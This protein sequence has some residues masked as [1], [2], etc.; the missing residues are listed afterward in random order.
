MPEEPRILAETD[1][2]LVLD[3]PSGWHSVAGATAA[4][5]GGVGV[6]ELWLRMHRPEC[7]A[8][9]EAGL[10]H[11][12]DRDTSGCLVVARDEPTRVELRHR[13]ATG[14]GLRK[15]YRARCRG[16]LDAAGEATLHFAPRRKG[17]PTVRV[18]AEGE[19]R[20]R[21]V[22]RWRVA[23]RDGSDLLVDVELVGPGRRHQ[24]RAA[25]AHLGAPIVGDALYGGA[26]AD[27]LALHAWRIELDGARVEAPIP[28]FLSP[29]EHPA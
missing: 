20:H 15:L 21:G 6:V 17:A 5:E 10:V 28:E 3:K 23:A 16:R 25:L 7:A 27:R 29:K 13:F 9:V 1:A 8:L 2:W 4:D 18:R 11:R 24:I 12:L 22:V 14:E 19:E 26:P